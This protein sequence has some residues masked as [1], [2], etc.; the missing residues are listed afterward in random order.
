M[1]LRG[2]MVKNQRC[3]PGQLGRVKTII[4]DHE[5]IHVI[6]IRLA[7]D[8]RSKDHQTSHCSCTPGRAGNLL[9]PKPDNSS[10][11]CT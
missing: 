2:G 3:D 9:K 5:D 4:H 11:W 7:R 1:S 8:E 10:L 6:R